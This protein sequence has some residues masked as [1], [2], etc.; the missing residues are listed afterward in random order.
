M[1]VRSAPASRKEEA[2]SNLLDGPA[3]LPCKSG[4]NRKMEKEK[5]NSTLQC[6]E[7]VVR[8]TRV[9]EAL[10]PGTW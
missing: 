4:V 7:V 10:V 8:I 6:A 5:E 2:V 9:N 3:L 1:L